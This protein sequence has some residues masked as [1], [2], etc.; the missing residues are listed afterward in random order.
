MQICSSQP[1]DDNEDDFAKDF[2]VAWNTEPL[3]ANPLLFWKDWWS[4]KTW[5]KWH[6][7]VKAKYGKDRANEVFIE[8]W[9]KAPAL[10]PTIDY[11]TFDEA[12]IAYAKENGFYDAL[13]NGIGGLLGKTA[14]SGQRVIKSAGKVIEATADIIE[15]TTDT[16]SFLGRN[17]KWVIVIA[18]LAVLTLLFFKFKSI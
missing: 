4:A 13:Y 5:I 14:G 1:F 11:R 15:N 18:V 17:F 2:N 6:T 10:S 7:A 8:W 9:E 12:F 16:V 3:L